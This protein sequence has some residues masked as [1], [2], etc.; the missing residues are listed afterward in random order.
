MLLLTPR[1]PQGEAP[2]APLRIAGGATIGRAAGADLVLGD[3]RNLVSSR[4]C[5]IDAADGGYVLTD[6]S[7]NGTMVNGRRVAGPQRLAAGDVLT[8]GPWQVAVG[9]AADADA[10]ASPPRVPPA[11][12]N[13]PP[14]MPTPAMPTMQQ[15]GL[16][17]TG[18][19][20]AVGRLLLAAGIPRTA[21]AG[22]DAAV[23]AAAGA[24]LRQ[25]AG[26]LSA[27]LAAREKARTELGLKPGQASSNPLKRQ[28]K[29]E[30]ALAQLLGAPA[31]AEQA[32]A[33]ALAELEAHQRAVLKAMQGAL[34]ATLDDLAPDAI[35]AHSP[36]SGDAA[37]W[38]LYAKAFAGTGS[39]DSFIDVFARE[40][41]TAYNRLA[42]APPR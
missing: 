25:L 2:V 26:G 5:R 19:G 42:G 9:I 23:L 1:G 16:P 30:A 11:D 3:Q 12:W 20:D 38:Q 4:H 8:I 14:A 33:E 24:L 37:L 27:M 21:V 28:A 17:D 15:P 13:R 6:T 22:N 32:V 39:D 7:T 18:G 36:K 29:P 41:G 40:L 31:A 34:R 10:G 35:R